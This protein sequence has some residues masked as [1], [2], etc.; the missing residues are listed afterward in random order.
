MPKVV[1]I[2]ELLMGATLVAGMSLARAK[3]FA[4]HGFC[5]SA[6]VIF[7]LAPILMFMLPGY[8]AA[9]LSGLPAHLNDRFYAVATAHAALGTITE[10]L[11]LYIVLVTGTNLLPHALRF[12][13]Y[14]RWMRTEIVLW[15]VVI[16][17]GIGTYCV[18]NVASSKPTTAQTKTVQAP[19]APGQTQ[20]VKTVN[21][22]IGNFAFDP[23][24]LQIE[25]GTTVIWKNVTG[26][27]SVTA[28]DSSFDSPIMAPGEEFKRSFDRPGLV[29]YFCKLH[30]GAGGEKMSGTIMVK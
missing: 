27:H 13:N 22:N 5:Q 23:K 25:A 12:K 26:R 28:D 30:G 18:W 20:T 1:L 4:A 7:N 16:C 10:V 19:A 9:A 2:A 3:R 8:R 29:K 17:F 24:D 14:R 6:V 11:G 15:W 21:I